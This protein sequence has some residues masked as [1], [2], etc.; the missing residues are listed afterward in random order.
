M[1]EYIRKSKLIARKSAAEPVSMDSIE[2][3]VGYILLIGVLLSVGLIISGT[4]WNLILNHSLSTSFT[5]SNVNYFDFFRSS[6]SQLFHGAIQPR[7]LISLGIA[8]LMLTP[9]LRVL[10]SFIYF[11]FF[12]RNMKYTLF[13]LFV[14]TV[15]T[16]SLFLR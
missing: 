1:M 15:L 10:A 5:I 2:L 7:L 12:A 13:T 6:L 8:T 9:Y 11:A 16:Y 3:M 14:F 4:V